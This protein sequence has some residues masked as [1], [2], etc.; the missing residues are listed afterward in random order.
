MEWTIAKGIVL[1][2]GLLAVIALVLFAIF[3][4]VTQL[5]EEA[6]SGVGKLFKNG[7]FR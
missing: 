3:K 5:F 2:V 6:T 7:P 1:G 4:V